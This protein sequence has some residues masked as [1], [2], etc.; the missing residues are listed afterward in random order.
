MNLQSVYIFVLFVLFQIIFTKAESYTCTEDNS[1]VKSCPEANINLSCS[2]HKV[3]ILCS[4]PTFGMCKI[5]KGQCM[6][7]KNKCDDICRQEGS[8]CRENGQICFL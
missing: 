2:I 7:A 1:E 8:V 6:D 5:V 4:D 3:E